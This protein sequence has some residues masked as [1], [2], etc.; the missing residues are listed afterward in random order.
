VRY[1]HAK[2]VV[3]RDL[4]PENFLLS[5]KDCESPIK[6]ID[7]GLSAYAREGEDDERLSDV[8]G[9]LGEREGEAE[10]ERREERQSERKKKR[11]FFSFPS[12]IKTLKKKK[13]SLGK[14]QARPTTWPPR[15]SA[16]G[17]GT[18]QTSGASA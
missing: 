13:L 17:T 2:G 5:T 10:R 12:L 1:L 8:V 3:H 9:E 6:M 11:L 16:G 14:K 18:R 15:S 4:K 7:F